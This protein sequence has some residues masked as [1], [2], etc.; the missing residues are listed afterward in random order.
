MVE[1]DEDGELWEAAIVEEE[2][3]D[4]SVIHMRLLWLSKTRRVSNK[5]SH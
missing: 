5:M 3:E 2:D 1:D 4:W